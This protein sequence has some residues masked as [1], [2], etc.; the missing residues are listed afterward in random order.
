MDNYRALTL[1]LLQAWEDTVNTGC[2]ETPTSHWL[3]RSHITGKMLLQG[4]HFVEAGMV[5]DIISTC[6]VEG[7]LVFRIS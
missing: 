1:E 7:A 6:I 2:R 3:Q 4:E 5:T